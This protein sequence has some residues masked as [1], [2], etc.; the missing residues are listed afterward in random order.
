MRES[1]KYKSFL[2]PH[3]F[4]RT[5]VTPRRGRD[6]SGDF[7]VS[8]VWRGECARLSGVHLMAQFG[9][10]F[11]IVWNVLVEALILIVVIATATTPAA[12]FRHGRRTKIFW[13]LAASGCS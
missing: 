12:T 10:P 9:N 1:A 11:Q 7:S 13:M 8:V 3:S 5:P 2:I 4:P 6:S